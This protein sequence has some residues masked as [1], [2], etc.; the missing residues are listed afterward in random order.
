MLASLLPPLRGLDV[1]DLGCGT[2]RLLN[3]ARN[4]GARS[5]IG[6]DVSPEM[7][8]IA[9]AKLGD[10]ATLVCAECTGAPIPAGCADVIF[11]NFVLSYLDEPEELLSFAKS[12]LRPG[13]S[14]FLSDVHPETAAAFDWRR[15]VS[16]RGE[17][18]E[19]RTHPRPLKEIVALCK[20]EKLE[21]VIQLELAF[22]AEER[23]I[24]EKNGKGEYF[25]TIR[26]HAAIYLLQAKGETKPHRNTVV[27]QK[28]PR[29]PIR[30][31]GARFALG[32]SDSVA[33]EMRIR[34]GHIDAIVAEDKQGSFTTGGDCVNLQGYLVLPGLVNAHDHLEFALFPRLGRGGYNNFLEWAEDIH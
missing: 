33:A 24:F 16:V 7:L 3:A 4:A 22:G 28:G 29:T 30:V 1:V 26:E 23:V 20:K 13:G 31:R 34:G 9:R 15:G 6:V 10:A 5:L 17:F 32:S 11:C 18:K 19:I 14:L 8:N 21:M 12:I 2:G 27:H 25:D